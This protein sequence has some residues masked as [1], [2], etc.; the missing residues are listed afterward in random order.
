MR[1][2]TASILALGAFASVAFAQ[3]EDAAEAIAS[4]LEA[5]ETGDEFNSLA[6]ALATDPAGIAAIQAWET[7]VQGALGAGETPGPSFLDGLP[8]VATAFFASVYTAELSIASAHGITADATAA[9]TSGLEPASSLVKSASA[10]ETSISSSASEVSKSASASQKSASSSASSAASSAS[11]AA[12]STASGSGAAPTGMV[13]G[14]SAGAL[15]GAVGV[16]LA[17]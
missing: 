12:S 7:S 6:S 2:S 3:A 11:A 8:T 4:Y 17:L 9:A 15:V 16:M 14:L 1:F 5:L 10:E 13:M